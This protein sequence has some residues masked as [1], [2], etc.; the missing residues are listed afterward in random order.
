[1]DYNKAFDTVSRAALWSK[2]LNSNVCGKIFNIIVNM[3]KSAKSCVAA[4]GLLSD[5]FSCLTG[6]RQGEN[7]SPLLFSLFLNE[8]T[9]IFYNRLKS[10]YKWCIILLMM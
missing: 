2:L 3:Y 10:I 1:M 7:L 4:N 5:N 6:V 8:L 9:F